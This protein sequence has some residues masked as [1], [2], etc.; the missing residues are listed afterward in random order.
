MLGNPH[1]VNKQKHGG[2]V[3]A[4][5]HWNRVFTQRTWDVDQQSKWIL[6]TKLVEHLKHVWFPTNVVWPVWPATYGFYPRLGIWE[7][8]PWNPQLVMGLLNDDTWYTK[9]TD[10]SYFTS[11]GTHTGILYILTLR[12]TYQY[13]LTFYLFLTSSLALFLMCSG[14]CPVPTS[15]QKHKAEEEKRKE[16]LYLCCRDPHLEGGEPLTIILP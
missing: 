5:W 10:N 8:N 6:E 12:P 3:I 9:T 11:S 1:I 7:T 15:W 14:P 4:N 16:E 13:I 2:W